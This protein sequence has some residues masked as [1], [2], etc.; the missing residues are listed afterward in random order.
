V[1]DIVAGLIKKAQLDD[2]AKAGPIRVYE[3][4]GNKIHRDLPREHHVVGITDYA[5]VVAERI[6]EDDVNADPNNLVPAF[7]FQSEP[8]KSHGTPFRFQ[9]KPVSDCFIAL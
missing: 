7:H 1:D 4:H 5:Q 9:M 6:P 8:S 2:E 3:V